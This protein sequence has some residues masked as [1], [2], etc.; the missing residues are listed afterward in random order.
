MASQVYTGGSGIEIDVYGGYRRSFGRFRF[1]HR[2]PLLPLPECG[3]PERR[4][5]KPGASTPR[6][7]ISGVRGK[8][9]S[10]K[11]SL[12]RQRLLRSWAD[13]GQWRLLV[14]R[15]A[16]ARCCRI[17][18]DPR[19]AYYLDLTASI[20]V[21]EKLTIGA[22][23]GTLKVENYGELDYT[24]W[25]LGVTYNLKGWLLGAAY[26]DTDA[27]RSG[28][29]RAARRATKT[30]GRRPSWFPWA[31][32]SEGPRPAPSRLARRPG[33]PAEGRAMVRTSVGSNP[34]RGEGPLAAT[35]S[36]SSWTISASAS[37][38]LSSS[39][40]APRSPLDRVPNSTHCMIGS[41]PSPSAAARPI[42]R[43]PA[44]VTSV[45]RAQ[46]P[47][48]PARRSRKRGLRNSL[49]CFPFGPHP[50][51]ERHQDGSE[52]RRILALR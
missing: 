36:I 46:V 30:P 51:C 42:T 26:V 20:P 37:I 19:T 16:T 18:V 43:P 52:A 39:F 41:T 17:A 24:D 31:G 49:V 13:P 7:S 8:W 9:I 15:R 34:N 32:H 35:G 5:R 45:S 2:L 40:V 1:R 23:V 22:H 38:C 3:V 48:I 33:G 25:K 6:M 28:T 4:G 29:T 27:M 12:R 21:G 50:R 47:L 14:E 44:P 10:L 11:Y